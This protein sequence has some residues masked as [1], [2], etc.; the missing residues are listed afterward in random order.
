MVS[1]EKRE[2]V[3]RGRA[4]SGWGGKQAG[5][6]GRE[7]EVAG[8]R[9]VNNAEEGPGHALSRKRKQGISGSG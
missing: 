1:G 5:R 7:G 8:Q 6:K 3:P 2:R 9:T 4:E